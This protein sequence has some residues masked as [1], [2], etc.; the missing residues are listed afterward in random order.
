MLMIYLSLALL[1]SVC[2]YRTLKES[3]RTNIKYAYIIF[4]LLTTA[5]LLMILMNVLIVILDENKMSLFEPYKY[6]CSMHHKQ[7][8]FDIWWDENSYWYERFNITKE[9]FESFPL[10]RGFSSDYLYLRKRNVSSDEIN[11]GD[12]AL[13]KYED[14]KGGF[15]GRVL[16]RESASNITHILLSRD[17]NRMYYESIKEEHVYAKLEETFRSKLFRVFARDVCFNVTN[18]G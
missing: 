8:K 2:L 10:K 15:T 7:K 16:G 18:I 4:I 3:F 14:S 9:T 11:I 6:S 17:N 13:Y 1:A 5:P 12:I